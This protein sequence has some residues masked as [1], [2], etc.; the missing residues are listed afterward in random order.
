MPPTI[1]SADDADLMEALDQFNRRMCLTEADRYLKVAAGTVSAAIR[2]GEIRPLRN[3]DP[4]VKRCY[5]TPRILAK[6]VN[7]YWQ[8]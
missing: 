5:V 1:V 8:Q 6:W 3:P 7:D 4:E 2:R